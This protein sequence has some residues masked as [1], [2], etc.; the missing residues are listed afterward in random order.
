MTEGQEFKGPH[1]NQP[2]LYGGS[3]VERAKGAMIMLH[4]RGEEARE[5]LSLAEQIGEPQFLY[6][7]PQARDSEWYPGGMLDPISGNEPGLT[8]GLTM[9]DDLLKGLAALAMPPEQ[10]IL[11]GFSQGACLALEYAVRNPRRYGAVVGLSGGLIGPPDTPRDYEGSLLGTPV[12]L[13]CAED[14]ADIPVERVRET[15]EALGSLRAEVTTR[16]Y[17]GL[18]HAVGDDEIRVVQ[19]LVAAVG[20]SR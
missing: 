2:V 20:D 11:F 17:P 14:D 13:G 1:Q 12:F 8:S 4:G 19:R 16:L 10:V 15:A 7:A 6:A 3:P 9:I 5:I 18:G